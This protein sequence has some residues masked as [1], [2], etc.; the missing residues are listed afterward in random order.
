MGLCS[1]KWSPGPIRKT[2]CP[3]QA[4]TPCKETPLLWMLLLLLCLFRDASIS[5]CSLMG[6]I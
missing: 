5:F 2:T 1:C 3:L 4:L 6:K